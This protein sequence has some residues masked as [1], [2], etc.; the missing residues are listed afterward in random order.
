MR[1]LVSILFLY[2]SIFCCKAAF[3]QQ[4][5]STPQFRNDFLTYINKV[6]KKGCT[7]GVNYMPPAPPLTWNYQLE[8][9]AIGHAADMATQ[10]YFNHTSLDGRTMKDRINATGYTL[11]GFRGIKI[12]ENIAFGQQSIAEVMQGWLNSEGHC[13]NLMGQGFK[14]IG[15]AR[16]NDYWVQDFGGRE[17]F[18]AEE[19]RL[20][21]SG[22]YK[23]VYSH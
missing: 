21:K 11:N 5:L 6:R 4:T 20:I 22:R 9:A 7:C 1:N 12:G 2:F 3:S 17:P 23:I 16:A 19:Q 14:E 13:K 18:T 8:S 15:I 10:H